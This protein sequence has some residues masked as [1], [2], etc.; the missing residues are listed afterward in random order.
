[1]SNL[2]LVRFPRFLRRLL[3]LPTSRDVKHSSTLAKIED[4]GFE[5]HDL[6]GWH[7]GKF[8]PRRYKLIGPA[9][10][11]V[12]NAGIG[13]ASSAEAYRAALV[14]VKARSQVPSEAESTS[15]TV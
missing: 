6:R 4:L 12:D 5:I 11:V 13:F 2:D 14:A 1:M 10:E 7:E 9:G 8:A 3:R 15:Q